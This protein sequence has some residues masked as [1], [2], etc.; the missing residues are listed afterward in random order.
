MQTA[1]A[2]Y[3]HCEGELHQSTLTYGT[4][5]KHGCRYPVTPPVENW[6]QTGVA[7]SVGRL[8]VRLTRHPK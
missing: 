8:S 6:G 2:L 4:S 7:A 5:D 1:A 3:V